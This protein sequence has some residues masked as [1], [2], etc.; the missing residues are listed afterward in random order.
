MNNCALVLGGYINGLSIIRELHENNVKDIW[1]FDTIRSIGTRSNKINGY[2]IIEESSSSLLKHIEELK[3]SYQKIVLYPTNDNHLEQLLEIFDQL[4]T[5]CFLPFNETNLLDCLNKYYQYQ[6]CENLSIP[7][8][9]TKHIR[10]IEDIS[11]AN[12]LEFPI[13]IKPSSRDDIGTNLF[14]SILISEPKELHNIEK[15]ITPFLSK[16]IQFIAS[17]Y[18]PGND[19][20]IYAYTAYRSRQGIILNEWIG[21]KLSQYPNLFGVFSSATNDAPEI[22][23]EQGRMLLNEMKIYG[24]AEPEFKYDSRDDTYKLTEINLRSMMWHRL[25]ALSGVNL[26]LTQWQDALGHTP[27]PNK[28][29][30]TDRIHY[31]YFKHEILNLLFRKNY[32]SNFTHNL[33]GG[34]INRFATFSIND[35]KPFL[36]DFMATIKSILSKCL[37]RLSGK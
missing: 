32:L 24:I 5:S 1:V 30:L 25:G 9:K 13:I 11:L 6:V 17:E 29:N 26:Q 8:P 3:N 23:A 33:F 10:S 34:N 18:I 14:R 27:S 37:T 19:D 31:I 16:G 2:K 35:M 7:Y 36:Y 21:K 12:D 22:I 28:Q 15:R 4:G 20:N